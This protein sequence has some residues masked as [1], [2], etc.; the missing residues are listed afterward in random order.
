MAAAIAPCSA[1]VV[2]TNLD[3]S[4]N[5]PWTFGPGDEDYAHLGTKFTTGSSQLPLQ[6]I[7]L[8]LSS[9]NTANFNLSIHENGSSNPGALVLAFDSQTLTGAN[10]WTQVTFTYTGSPVSLNASTQ[11]W[12]D[13]TGDNGG[14]WST[15]ASGSGYTGTGGVSSSFNGILYMMTW[16]TSGYLSDSYP[17]QFAITSGTPIPEPSSF[18]IAAG[19]GVIAYAG[20]RR[21]KNV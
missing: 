5:A 4:S 20:F 12:L 15:A 10:G 1:D 13:L 6:S 8:L 11:Y 14:S 2:L 21:R 17:A 18:A 16:D 9:N 3:R 7:T 19:L